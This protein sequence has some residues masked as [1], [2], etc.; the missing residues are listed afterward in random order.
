MIAE[1]FPF[2]KVTPKAAQSRYKAVAPIQPAFIRVQEPFALPQGA[3]AIDTSDLLRFARSGLRHYLYFH[4]LKMIQEKSLQEEEAFIFSPLSKALF[5]KNVLK[6]SS[7]RAFKMREREGD[8]PLGLFGKLA[9]MQVIEEIASLPKNDLTTMTLKPFSLPINSSLTVTLTGTIEGVF[10]EGLCVSDKEGFK[11]AAKAWPLFLL[12]NRE[13]ASKQKLLFAPS[14]G[15]KSCFF[16]DPIPFLV[17]YLE[18]FFYA[19]A[20]PIPLI[21]DWIEP[22]LKRDAKKMAQ[23][24]IHD[25]IQQWY[26]RG[27]KSSMYEEVIEAYHPLI[28]KVYQGMQ[29]AWF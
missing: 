13:D 6:T 26:L 7:D 11:G 9:E 25:P 3:F 14:Q 1:L 12:L 29:D 4:D 5:R 20:H 22:I 28:E 23:I 19:K 17:S 8:I 15:L 10:S 27:K 24:E 2:I 18:L 21:P 16:E